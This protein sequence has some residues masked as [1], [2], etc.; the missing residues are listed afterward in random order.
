MEP[1]TET[2]RPLSPE[3]SEEGKGKKKKERQPR[4]TASTHMTIP[5]AHKMAKAA[6]KLLES[7]RVTEPVNREYSDAEVLLRA[8]LI[9][10][11]YG[12]K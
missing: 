4:T 7:E 10:A 8:Y 1:V 5:L 12:P 3:K 2:E 9:E 11:G 6:K